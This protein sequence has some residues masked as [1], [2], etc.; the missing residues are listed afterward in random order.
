MFTVNQQT[1]D[2]SV[3]KQQAVNFLCYVNTIPDLTFT[4]Y[5]GDLRRVMYRSPVVNKLEYTTF[6]SSCDD[7]DV[8]ICRTDDDVIIEKRI[9]VNVNSCKTI[10]SM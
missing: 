1:T 8:Y 5:K 6:M 3:S 9:T 7:S 10:E 4:L 2:I